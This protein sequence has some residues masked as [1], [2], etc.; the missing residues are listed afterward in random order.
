[1]LMPPTLLLTRSEIE[2]L[3]PADA[4][5]DLMERAFAR[6]ADGEAL[7]SRL[8]HLDSEPGEFHIKAS[9]LRDA[10]STVVAVKIGA[11][12]YDRPARLGLPSIVGVIALFSGD[13]G[14]PLALMES[15]TVTRLRTAAATAVA[16]RH[17]ALDGADTLALCGTGEQAAAHV[18][19]LLAVRPLRRILVWSR[20]Q[21][22]AAAFAADLA[23]RHAVEASAVPEPGQ[24]IRESRIVVTLTPAREP[25]VDRRDVAPG[26]FVAAV[27]SDAPDKQELQAE[28]LKDAAV[29]VDVLHQC[30]EV[31]ELHHAIEAG[32][33]TADDVR[34]E[35]GEVVTGARPGRLSPEEIV[36]FDSTGTAVQ[37]VA[38]A[39]AL[40]EAARKHDAGRPLPLWD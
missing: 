15:A 24:A 4:Y 30:A 11:C 33:L 7:P 13:D 9:G 25:Y 40:Y 32:A 36:V 27:G 35:L 19:A 29:I 23:G 14:Q 2:R 18:D 5:I 3:L 31:G 38:A 12:F 22:R 37:D 39:Q 34:A 21:E 16:A 20:D 10:G 8:A 17:L 26:T 28:L 1:M 6:R